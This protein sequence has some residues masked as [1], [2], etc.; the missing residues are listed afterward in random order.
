[1]K[2]NSILS[3]MFLITSNSFSLFSQEMSP[4]QLEDWHLEEKR[5]ECIKS[6]DVENFREMYHKDFIGWPSRVTSPVGHSEL[7]YKILKAIEEGRELP[8][9]RLRREAVKIFDDIAIVHYA[10]S[11]SLISESEDGTDSSKWMKVTHTWM[12]MGDTWKIIGGMAAPLNNE[13]E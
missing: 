5:I 6:R 12:R 10:S 4:E 13:G 11:R 7:G 9:V 3:I 1:M 8:Q 2:M